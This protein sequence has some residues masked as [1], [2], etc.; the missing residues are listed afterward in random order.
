MVIVFTSNSHPFDWYPG[1]TDFDKAAIER[2]I[3]EIT[4]VE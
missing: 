2:R 1:I 3:T 4:V